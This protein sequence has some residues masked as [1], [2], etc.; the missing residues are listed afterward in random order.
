LSTGY[1]LI[2]VSSGKYFIKAFSIREVSVISQLLPAPLRVL[3][4]WFKEYCG[5]LPV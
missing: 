2:T 5:S 1:L 4:G 3:I